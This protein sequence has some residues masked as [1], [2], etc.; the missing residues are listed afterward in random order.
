MPGIQAVQLGGA[1][2]NAV[3][4]S[5]HSDDSSLA[6]GAPIVFSI[7]GIT[8][9]SWS[10]AYSAPQGSKSTLSVS[11]G[12]A[13]VSPVD[14]P[15]TYEVSCTVDTGATYELTM[16]VAQSQSTVF[17]GPLGVYYGPSSSVATPLVGQTLFS[18]SSNGGALSAKD[19]TGVVS[20]V[21]GAV[22]ADPTVVEVSPKV[23][24]VEFQF[25]TSCGEAPELYLKHDA[26]RNLV[27]TERSGA[28][29]EGGYNTLIGEKAGGAITSGYSNT[30]IGASAGTAT[31][32][33]ASNTFVGAGATSIGDVTNSGAFGAAAVVSEND[34]VQIG[35][36]TVTRVGLGAIDVIAG[37]LSA[38]PGG[39]SAP[40]GSLYTDSYDGSVW[41]NTTGTTS[42]WDRLVP[43]SQSPSFFSIIDFISA[44]GTLSVR[45]D[46]GR[47]TYAVKI[48]AVS[49]SVV[50]GIRFRSNHVGTYRATLWEG[51][52]LKSTIDVAESA[53]SGFRNTDAIFASTYT[54]VPGSL[55]TLGVYLL[56]E[57]K[58]YTVQTNSLLA[59][60]V[61][62]TPMYVDGRY[63]F[64]TP[65]MF[66]AG[67][68]L[69]LS[70][71]S[72]DKGYPVE[73]IFV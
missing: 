15:G 59:P 65:N 22:G 34:T 23:M 45:T 37:S 56:D 27:L 68:A 69:P 7:V 9:T 40:V 20:I 2:V 25:G 49:P 33:G 64:L 12:G 55:Y 61:S 62:A 51:D 26:N 60:V 21:G 53:G 66:G 73:P 13:S 18:D 44:A 70:A 24:R 14:L 1:V 6:T 41:V 54:L 36:R 17:P 5:P 29:P 30:A 42:G 16:R 72:N 57:S 58:S 4:A 47:F 43:R 39:V 50:K 63:Q 67:D 31:I 71:G 8:P 32:S 11:P 19:T 28:P 52:I 46:D 48:R 3:G 10:W 35:S 38:G